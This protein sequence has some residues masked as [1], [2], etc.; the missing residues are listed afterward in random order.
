MKRFLKILV[1]ADGRDGG[2]TALRRAIHLARTNEAR[3]TVAEVI[4]ELPP[5]IRKLKEI[6]S[7]AEL[8]EMARE[9]A[10]QGLDELL[11]EVDTVGVS[12]AQ[13]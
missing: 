2:R 13:Y 1:H 6:K 11:S 7:V 12:R 5:N 10:Q 3:L 8:K 9:D 4:P